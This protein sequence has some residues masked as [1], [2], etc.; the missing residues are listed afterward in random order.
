VSGIVLRLI[1]YWHGPPATEG[2][3]DVRAFVA[4]APDPGE[5][6]AVADYLRSGTAFVA[7]AGFSMCRICGAA[8]GS[9]ELTDGVHFVWP[10][11]LA[12]YVEAHSVRLPDEVVAVAAGGPAPPVDLDPFTTA[13]L[14]TREVTIDDGWWRSLAPRRP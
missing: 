4:P 5:R 13:L 1:G 6:Q 10:E 8:N 12:H 11:G 7:A 2:W 14:E 3:P 9:T